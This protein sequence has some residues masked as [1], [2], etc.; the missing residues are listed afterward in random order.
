VRVIR[1]GGSEQRRVADNALP[2]GTAPEDSTRPSAERAPASIAVVDDTDVFRELAA[3][4][5]RSAGDVRTFA[6]GREALDAFASEP[7]DV[8]VLD[9]DMPLLDGFAVLRCL[10]GDTALR[11]VPVIAFTAGVEPER[12]QDYR[13]AGFDGFVGKPL[14]D[15]SQ[16]VAE[17]QRVL[18]WTSQPDG[19]A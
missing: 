7:P 6:S 5:L 3:A 15:A 12:Q 10:R 9:I 8:V 19:A 11:H 4:L 18:G 16:L 2:A 17:V 1:T 14:R 13:A